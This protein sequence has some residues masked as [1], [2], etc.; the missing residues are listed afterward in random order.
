AA[1]ISAPGF[2]LLHHALPVVTP[3]ALVILACVALLRVLPE[4]RLRGWLVTIRRVTLFL[5]L[6]TALP[7][8]VQHMRLALFPQLGVSAELQDVSGNAVGFAGGRGKPAMKAKMEARRD[9]VAASAPAPAPD[10]SDAM[11]SLSSAPPM[12][13]S[14]KESYN[15]APA[16]Q[17]IYQY[18]PGMQ[19]NTGFGVAGWEGQRITLR[20][21]GPVLSTQVVSLWLLSPTRS[22][23]WV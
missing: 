20:W 22:C 3:Y 1:A 10:L 15:S 16:Q 12:E 9:E 18:D 11:A 13:M 6:L 19:S 14:A 7:F 8:M 17:E 5:L 2:L 23:C 21:N 4:G